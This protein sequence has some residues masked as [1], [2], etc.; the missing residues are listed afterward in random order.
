MGV[1]TSGNAFDMHRPP[2]FE[3]AENLA[4][5]L[6]TSGRVSAAFTQNNGNNQNSNAR[7]PASSRR[8][9]NLPTGQ[10]AIHD[11]DSDLPSS[12]NIEVSSSASPGV[13][14]VDPNLIL[15]DG[16]DPLR[17]DDMDK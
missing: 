9:I 15:E 7:P 5:D 10:V 13:R 17:A 1:T 16:R 2:Q 11:D 12:E 3:A 14:G 4:I 8:V 6:N